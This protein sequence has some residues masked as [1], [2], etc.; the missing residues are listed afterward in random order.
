VWQPPKDM[1]LDVDED[2]EL[3][4]QETIRRYLHTLA[5][6]NSEELREKQR[7]KDPL[8]YAINIQK[9]SYFSNNLWKARFPIG[10]SM[11]NTTWF[12]QNLHKCDS[13]QYPLILLKP[14]HPGAGATGSSE[15]Q[16]A[17]VHEGS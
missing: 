4:D 3:D 9:D 5:W 17:D 11:E 6:E 10:L 13:T 14:P 15:V 16:M 12:Q 1:D 2:K 7:K 8:G